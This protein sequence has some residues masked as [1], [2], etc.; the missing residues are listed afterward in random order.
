MKEDAKQEIK[1]ISLEW[2]EKV[3]G[4]AIEFVFKA[5]EVVI[6][7]SDNKLDDALLAVLPKLKEKVLTFVDRIDK[8]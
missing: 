5:I 1:A 8:K 6:K 2:T 4:Q 7:D 3:I